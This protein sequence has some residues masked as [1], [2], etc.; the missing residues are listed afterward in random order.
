MDTPNKK[1]HTNG[2][3]LMHDTYWK[4]IQQNTFTRWVNQQL[5]CTD[6]AINSLVLIIIFREIL[7]IN[8]RKPICPMEFVF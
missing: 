8:L 1:N 7:T 2:V 3:E 6:S 4:K 5:K